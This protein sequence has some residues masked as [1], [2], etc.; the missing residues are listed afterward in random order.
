MDVRSGE[1]RRRQLRA[2]VAQLVTMSGL[3]P[4]EALTALAS[5]MADV[6]IE[7][8]RR[9]FAVEAIKAAFMGPRTGALPSSTR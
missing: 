1:Q 8:G 2:T 7:H 5:V 3:E 6:A 4:S 9:E